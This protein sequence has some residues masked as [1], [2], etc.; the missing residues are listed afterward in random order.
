L[1]EEFEKGDTKINMRKLGKK[2]SLVR[3]WEG[4]YDFGCCKDGKGF[5]EQFESNKT[6]IL[7]DLDGKHWE[8]VRKDLKIY[9]LTS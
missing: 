5:Q 4:P 8:W 3:S 1:F 6:C 9:H 7:K 2:I